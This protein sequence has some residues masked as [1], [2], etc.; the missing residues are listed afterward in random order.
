MIY[1]V[2]KYVYNHSKLI[3]VDI[4]SHKIKKPNFIQYKNNSKMKNLISIFLISFLMMSCNDSAETT[5][6]VEELATETLAESCL[7]SVNTND[8]NFKWTAFKTTAKVG[9]N[10]SFDAIQ[11]ENETI[12]ED[13]KTLISN[14]KFKIELASVNSGNEERDGKLKEFFFGKLK[15]S[16]AFT[17][18]VVSTEGD[19][20][21]GSIVVSL[22][23]NEIEKDVKMKYAVVEDTLKLKTVLD[24]F[25]WEAND[26]VASIND[27]CLDLHKGADGVSKTWSDMEISIHVPIMKDCK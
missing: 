14:T 25:D 18:S 16:D 10:G 24:L 6:T 19:N 9:V 11:V 21:G 13:I 1:A 23:M 3:F 7:Y 5:E 17:G 12:A 4:I 26:A 20:T 15:N 2:Q 8:I 27:A 22:K